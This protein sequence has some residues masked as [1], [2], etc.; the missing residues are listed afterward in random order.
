MPIRTVD[1]SSH[2]NQTVTR[3]GPADFPV[4]LKPV[5]YQRNGSTAEMSGRVVVVREDTN[6]PLAIVW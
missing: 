5:L 4:A 3:G 1:L 6:Q 2:I